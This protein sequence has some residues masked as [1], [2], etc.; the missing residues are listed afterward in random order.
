MSLSDKQAKLNRK[1]LA[2]RKFSSSSTAADSKVSGD[3]DFITAVKVWAYPQKKR[4]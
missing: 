3:S 4:G 1:W 2:V